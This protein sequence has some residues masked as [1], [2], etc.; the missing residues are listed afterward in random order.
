MAGVGGVGGVTLQVS[1]RVHG[2][3][4]SGSW[5]PQCLLGSNTLPARKSQIKDPIRL[6]HE[7]INLS[8][9]HSLLHYISLNPPP[10]SFCSSAAPGGPA[11]DAFAVQTNHTD[12]ARFDKSLLTGSTGSLT[13]V[14]W[15]CQPGKTLTLTP[16]PA[17]MRGIQRVDFDV[18]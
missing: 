3:F 9:C 5:T 6:V 18:R 17:L 8:L 15:D 7:G 12:A 13:R 1:E 10:L 2:R 16:S 14:N 4:V 11:R